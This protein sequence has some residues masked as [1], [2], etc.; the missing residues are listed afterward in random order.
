M[1]VTLDGVYASNPTIG[2]AHRAKD[3]HLATKATA[4]NEP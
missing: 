3:E 4:K 2:D 1:N